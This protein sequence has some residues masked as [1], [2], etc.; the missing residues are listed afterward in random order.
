MYSESETSS[1]MSRRQRVKQ[2]YASK[3]ARTYERM[4]PKRTDW[5][6][7]GTSMM[8]WISRLG[9]GLDLSFKSIALFVGSWMLLEIGWPVLTMLGVATAGSVWSIPSSIASMY[10]VVYGLVLVSG[11]NVVRS[12]I[13]QLTG[14]KDNL[15][16]ALFRGYFWSLLVVGLI[17][18]I[19]HYFHSH[20]PLLFMIPIVYL[21]PIQIV[22]N[23]VPIPIPL[24]ITGIYMDIIMMVIVYVVGI[25]GSSIGGLEIL[26]HFLDNSHQGGH[27]AILSLLMLAVF[28]AM[29]IHFSLVFLNSIL[30]VLRGLILSV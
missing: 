16:K 22:G 26:R 6:G 29:N 28:P 12:L 7:S 4:D 24:G 10:I 30:D 27:S 21:L 15:V 5:T 19:H 3:M 9:A 18:T 17:L 13:V 23:T 1:D 14:Q 25:T 20:M 11:A 2:Y 8:G